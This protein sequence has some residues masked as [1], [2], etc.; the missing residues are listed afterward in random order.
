MLLCAAL[1]RCRGK[2]HE[3]GGA[4]LNIVQMRTAAPT[5]R[6]K[7]L[8]LLVS[9]SRRNRLVAVTADEMEDEEPLTLDQRVEASNVVTLDVA[10]DDEPPFDPP[11]NDDIF[12]VEETE[13]EAAPAP[14]SDAGPYEALA[15]AIVEEAP[16]EEVVVEEVFVEPTE[17]AVEPLL[18]DEAAEDD[19]FVA[20][21]P[22]EAPQEET[23]VEFAFASEEGVLSASVDDEEPPFD[24]PDV[25]PEPRL[26][27]DDVMIGLHSAPADDEEPPFDAPDADDHIFTSGTL[28]RVDAEEQQEPQEW[29]PEGSSD[30]RSAIAAERSEGQR[31]AEQ[32]VPAIKIYAAWERDNVNEMFERLVADPR[33]SRADFEVERGGIERAIERFRDQ[34]SPDLLVLD[35]TL[36]ASEMLACLDRLA[37]V[38]EQG[39][40]LIVIGAV[41]DIGLLRDLA[42]RGISDYMV[43]PMRRDDLVRAICA[44]YTGEHNSRVIAVIGASGGVGASTIAHNIAWSIAERQECGA[45]LIDLDLSFGTANF[46]FKDE[47]AKTVAD[48]LSDENAD[49]TFI[50]HAAVKPSK[51][52]R[53]LPAPAALE[54]GVQLDV[55]ALEQLLVRA[56]RLSPFVVLDLP[57]VWS[58]WVKQ[59][60]ASAD[61]VVVVSAPDL[62]SLR[63]TKNMLEQFKHLRPRAH[64]PSVVLSMTGMPKRPEILAKDFAQSLDATPVASF[65]FEPALFGMAAIS[66]KMLGDAAPDSKAALQMDELATSLT[67]RPAVSAKKPT[68]RAT[69]KGAD[70]IQRMQ[71]PE[72][73]VRKPSVPRSAPQPGAEAPKPAPQP[74]PVPPVPR[75]ENADQPLAAAPEQKLEL[76]PLTLDQAIEAPS[77]DYI[78]KARDAVL[79]DAAPQRRDAREN[80]A[81]SLVLSLALIASALHVETA[82]VAAEAQRPF[83]EPT[84]YSTVEAQ[85]APLPAPIAADPAAIYADAVELMQSGQAEAGAAEMQ[86]AAEAGHAMAQYRMALAYE[87]GEGVEIDLAAARIWTERAAASGVAMAMHNLGVYNARGEGAARDEA[88]AFRWFRQAAEFGVPDSQYNL[89]ILYQRGRGVSEDKAEALFWFLLAARQ[90]DAQ[91]TARVT[92]I[93]SMLTPDDARQARA[94]AD[95]FRPRGAAAADAT[96]DGQLVVAVATSG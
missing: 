10:T 71:A 47:A 75:V 85:P 34:T 92:E 18:L 70:A 74:M 59:T 36:N 33:M 83:V 60:L 31:A 42:A 14:V 45:T 41:N 86:R 16:A 50:E 93:E 96:G 95:A 77:L 67:G 46:S 21:A 37:H 2:T 56:R 17:P 66:G 65:A 19:A 23:Q 11:D 63:N 87:R 22:P 91:A 8:R 15:A 20:E 94:R 35:T 84:S 73:N 5:S 55:P 7:R 82:R 78:D 25:E 89:G 32:P 68:R 51:R 76:L 44:L 69:P 49:D 52:L 48:V 27:D 4:V 88:A 29:L 72:F 43:A 80:R 57:H 28:Q 61:D 39:A 38:L 62:A 12:G 81:A 90:G 9:R 1:F 24:A 6:R 13:C 58:S 53:V 79:T 54:P 26:E 40:K 30:R 3:G 64:A